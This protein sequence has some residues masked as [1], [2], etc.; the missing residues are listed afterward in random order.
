VAGE[1]GYFTLSVA[2]LARAQA[3]YGAVLGWEFAPEE[4]SAHITN[5]STPGGLEV[6]D[7]PA[8][9]T[10]YFR[11]DDIE[12]GVARVR[13]GGGQAGEIVDSPSGRNAAC[14][15]EQGTPFSLWEP[16]AGY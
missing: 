10:L 5:L 3:F 15:D 14:H 8:V 2:D 12:A 1:L 4:T 11:V 6:A 9:A 16:A 7:K 13:A